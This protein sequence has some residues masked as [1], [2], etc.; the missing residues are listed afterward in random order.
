MPVFD[1]IEEAPGIV[2]YTV[3]DQQLAGIIDS[4]CAAMGLPCVSVLEPVLIGVPVLSRCAGAAAGSVPSMC[5]TPSISAAST[6]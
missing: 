4:R 1:D 6:R 2:L 5:S 3:V